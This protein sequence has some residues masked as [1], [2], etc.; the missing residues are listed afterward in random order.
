MKDEIIKIQA[1]NGNFVE[2]SY[3]E[4]EEVIVKNKIGEE[5]KQE[6]FGIKQ[7]DAIAS[8]NQLGVYSESAIKEQTIDLSEIK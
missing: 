5:E 2:I 4:N 6:E 1:S 8:N 7:I 3:K